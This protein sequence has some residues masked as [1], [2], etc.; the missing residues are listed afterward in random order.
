MHGAIQK[1]SFLLILVFAF[2]SAAPAE[3]GGKITAS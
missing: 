2:V 1:F 3:V